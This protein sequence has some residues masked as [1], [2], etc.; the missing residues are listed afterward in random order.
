MYITQYGASYHAIEAT[1]NPNTGKPI[2]IPQAVTVSNISK[3]PITSHTYVTLIVLA[4]LI[5]VA[6]YKIVVVYNQSTNQSL[7]Y[8]FIQA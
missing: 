2:Y 8:S 5:S 6:W 3:L 7:L 1:A 4:A